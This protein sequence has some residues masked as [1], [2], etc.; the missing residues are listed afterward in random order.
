[1]T[2]AAADARKTRPTLSARAFDAVDIAATALFGIEGAAAAAHAGLDLLGIVVVGFL[3]A[4]AGGIIR[5]M[6]LGDLP[7]AAFRSPSRIIVALAAS[8]AAFLLVGV[9]DVIPPFLLATLDAV[10]LA[11]FAVTGAQKAY[12]HGCNLWVVTILGGITATGG[13]VLRDIILQRTPY[14]LSESV[15]GTAALAGA[16]ATGIVLKTTRMPRLALACGFGVA[17][18]LRMLAVIFDW[19]LPRLA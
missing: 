7:P 15:Y 11:L 10:G 3:V 8:V 17:F 14:V 18:V 9:V 13:G 19:Q 1:M 6:L 16:F 4:L 12:E 2:T 5:D